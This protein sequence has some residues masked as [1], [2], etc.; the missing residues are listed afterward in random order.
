MDSDRKHDG[1]VRT[2]ERPLGLPRMTGRP[3]L[4][5]PRMAGEKPRGGILLLCW[6]IITSAPAIACT[7]DCDGNDRVAVDELVRAVGISLDT[8]SVEQCPSADRDLNG[9]VSVD[10][11]VDGVG[12]ALQG[13]SQTA[14]THAFVLATNFQ[15][16]SFATIALDQ[17]RTVSP[18]TPRRRV[19]SDA[20]ARVRNGLVYVVNRLFA[21]NIQVLDPAA[22]FETRLQCSTGN[23][24]NP[25]DIAFAD[26]SKAYVTLFE[27]SRLLIV[28]PA[29]RTDCS[30]FIRGEIDLTGVADGDGIPDMDLMAVVG[31]RLYVSI[32]R[33]DINT[34]LRLPAANG[35]I[36]VIDTTTDALVDTIELS[37][38]NPFAA[39]KGL[40]VRGEALYVSQAGLFG[41]MDGGIER[42]NL[43]THQPEGY[44]ITEDDLGGDVVDFVLISDR[45]AYAVVSRASFDTAL[46]SFDPSTAQVLDTV[47]AVDGFTLLD[48]EVNDRGELFVTD[49]ARA[50]D[51]IRIYR[52]A[53]GAPITS[54]P[55]DIGLSPFEVVF[56]P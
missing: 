17:P 27:E 6:I 46:V 52:V 2:N 24:S 32:Q 38:E 37:G 15:A 30:D 11:L 36:A 45:L 12:R 4:G 47:L 25:H 21:D 5:L 33:L 54:E 29:A 50:K 19:H 51:G 28:N 16:G 9:R 13:C 26:D 8:T 40:T 34:V 43:R 56:L 18:A 31:D 48:I 10:E 22:E 41:V 20:T 14:Q 44:F 49:R 23:G 3:P 35:A 53:D 55:L 42:I 1:I 39:T 7:G